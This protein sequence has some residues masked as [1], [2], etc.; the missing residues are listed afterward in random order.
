MKA[1]KSPTKNIRAETSEIVP[2]GMRAQL[3]FR[4]DCEFAQSDQNLHWAQF[5]IAK[6]AKLLHADNRDAV[7]T[8]RVCRLICLRPEHMSKGT[9]LDVLAHI[10]GNTNYIY[11]S[12]DG[13]SLENL[14]KANMKRYKVN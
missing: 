5:W 10:Y 2:P 11:S 1:L 12:P 9:F 14:Q 8:A 13:T 7:Q 3:S 4:S 6:V